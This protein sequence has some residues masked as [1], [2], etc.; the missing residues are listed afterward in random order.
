MSDKYRLNSAGRERFP[1][2]DDKEYAHSTWNSKLGGKSIAIEN[3]E[4][5]DAA[6]ITP[7]SKDLI[8]SKLIWD[9]ES[10]NDTCYGRKYHGN[11]RNI[12]DWFVLLGPKYT[13]TLLRAEILMEVK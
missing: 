6:N 4:I 11:V 13:R 10:G 1:E 5:V 9:N 12:S 3:I 7:L 2:Y 8:G